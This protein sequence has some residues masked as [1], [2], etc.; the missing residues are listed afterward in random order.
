MLYFLTQVG[1]IASFTPISGSPV[2]IP[3]HR[4]WLAIAGSVGQSRDRNP[5]AAYAIF[6]SAAEQI[7][8]YRVPYDH[9]AAARR[10]REA[11]LP[12]DLALRIER[13]V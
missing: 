5:A 11:G 1:K 7:T 9:L 6:D 12:E 13:A 10:I 2:P 4:R 8:F 3:S